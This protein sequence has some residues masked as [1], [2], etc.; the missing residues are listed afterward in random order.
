MGTRAV[1]RVSGDY[2][3][4]IAVSHP[5]LRPEMGMEIAKYAQRKVDVLNLESNTIEIKPFINLISGNS[6]PALSMMVSQMED[7]YLRDWF[8]A[9]VSTNEN[10]VLT[11]NNLIKQT[12]LVSIIGGILAKLERAWGQPIDIEFTA[13]V[14]GE[15]N[16]RINLLQCRSLRVP[17]GLGIELRIPDVLSQEQVLF[18]SSRAISAGAVSDICYVIYVDPKKYAEI[19]TLDEKKTLGRVIGKLN[20]KLHKLEGRV[21]IMGPGRWGSSNIELGVNV[22]YSDIDGT[23][24]LV[25]V[26]R[27]KAGHEPEVSY[28]THFFQDLVEAEILY[29]PVYPDN[30][31]ADFN[32]VFFAQSP[33]M[34]KDLMP[35]LSSFEKLVQ[36]IDIRAATGGAT[37]KVIAE[38]QNRRAVCFLDKD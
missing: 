18:R 33:N 22:S 3:R 13:Y 29:L 34:L 19:A 21:M 10:L 38:P 4:M 17:K 15:R 35:E 12:N 36:V 28:G 32:T 2:P 14:D 16:V 24:V 26:A 5:Q 27:E 23:A 6:Y 9:S 20:E 25:E 11:F 8:T 30:K 37:A 1:N 7:G 31:A